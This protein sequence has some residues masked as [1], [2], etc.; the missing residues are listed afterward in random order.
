MD[1]LMRWMGERG[2]VDKGWIG[3][4]SQADEWMRVD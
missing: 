4:L 1:E 2:L 3:E